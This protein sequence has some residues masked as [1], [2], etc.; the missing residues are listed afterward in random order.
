MSNESN[1][2]ASNGV[3]WSKI[4]RSGVLYA[5]LFCVLYRAGDYLA[6]LL[7][8]TRRSSLREWVLAAI[9]GF[10]IGCLLVLKTSAQSAARQESPSATGSP[11]DG[12]TQ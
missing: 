9:I 10:L 6:P 12:S 5:V 8:W 4:A 3:A 1:P 2:N 7:G 11:N